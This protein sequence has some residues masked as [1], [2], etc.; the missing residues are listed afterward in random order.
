MQTHRYDAI[1]KVVHHANGR[2][3]QLYE[4]NE[5]F[6]SLEAEIAEVETSLK[7]GGR[8]EKQDKLLVIEH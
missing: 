7:E 8:I 3:F 6:P 2:L 1:L 4:Q 5:S